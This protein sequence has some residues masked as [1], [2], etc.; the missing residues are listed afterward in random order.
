M[1]NIHGNRNNTNITNMAKYKF[2]A[3]QT[4]F[5]NPT[6]TINGDVGTK[7]VNNVPPRS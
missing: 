4:V 2:P 5:D 1:Q 7:V 3:F 6:I